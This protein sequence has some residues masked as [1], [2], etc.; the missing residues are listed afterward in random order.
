[1][2]VGFRYYDNFVPDE[3]TQM[4]FYYLDEKELVTCSGVSKKWNVLA[5]SDF[6]WEPLF[7]GLK[8][9]YSGNDVISIVKKYRVTRIDSCEKLLAMVKKFSCQLTKGKKG[10]MSCLFPFSPKFHFNAKIDRTDCAKQDRFKIGD[11]DLQRVCIF[12]KKISTPH[13]IQVDYTTNSYLKLQLK[14]PFL[15]EEFYKAYL[16]IET[17]FKNDIPL[18]ITSQSI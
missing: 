15:N 3:I 8:T 6:L 9:A 13:S 16:E 18:A 12:V 11:S 1:M 17:F 2:Q 14:Y 7:P 10:E 5:S 4:Y